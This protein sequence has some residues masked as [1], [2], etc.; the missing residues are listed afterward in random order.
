MLKREI[1]KE[2]DN[3]IDNE[4]IDSI[5]VGEVIEG[6]KVFDQADYN[7]YL[8]KLSESSNEF[9]GKELSELNKLLANSG[10]QQLG[11]NTKVIN[12]ALN[13]INEHY[14]NNVITQPNTPMRTTNN[15]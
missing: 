9:R 11:P 6:I 4:F 8:K 14:K 1:K 13:K 10:I 12:N 3:E 2:I 5:D 15:K 7:T